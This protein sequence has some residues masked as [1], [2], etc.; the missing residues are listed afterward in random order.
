MGL[1]HWF[2]R[3]PEPA[4]RP[5]A[6]RILMLS[7]SAEDRA[8]LS[9]AAQEQGWSFC[10]ADSIEE[11][12]FRDGFEII[13]C[14]RDHDSHPWREVLDQILGQCPDA[15]VI[16]LSPVYDGYLWREVVEHGGYD[17]LPTP[18]T[19]KSVVH[20]INS[21]KRLIPAVHPRVD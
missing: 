6:L 15:Y 18:L 17:V 20:A 5:A 9:R 16:L 13:L 1:R 14:D 11:N 4:A 12:A 21:A 2:S 7:R 3:R 8:V 19:E 10:C